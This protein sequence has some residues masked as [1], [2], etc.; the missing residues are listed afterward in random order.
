M[1]AS[2]GFCRAN[3]VPRIGKP[4]AGAQY[5]PLHSPK[6]NKMNYKLNLDFRHIMSCGS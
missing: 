5:F 2:A 4:G 6:L 1:M 3:P